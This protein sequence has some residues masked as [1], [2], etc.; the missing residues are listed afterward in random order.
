MRSSWGN[1]Q[2]TSHAGDKDQAESCGPLGLG[3]QILKFM[4]E[5]K[6]MVE[7]KRRNFW[8]KKKL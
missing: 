4:A 1:A 5:L 2:S 6:F 7:L 8:E 3:S